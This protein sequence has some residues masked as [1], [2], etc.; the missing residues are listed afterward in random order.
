MVRN[1]SSGD[2]FGST[3]NCLGSE[4]NKLLDTYCGFKHISFALVECEL[5][6]QY[7]HI[8]F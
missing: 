4:Q 2:V 1:F 7:T 6:Y 3:Q 8:P 5:V